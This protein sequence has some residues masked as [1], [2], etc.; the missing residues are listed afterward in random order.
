M[1]P[2]EAA[3]GSLDRVGAGAPTDAQDIVR[4]ALRHGC[5]VPSGARR[6]ATRRGKYAPGAW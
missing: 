2:R 4:V 5:S 6:P 3:P 1:L